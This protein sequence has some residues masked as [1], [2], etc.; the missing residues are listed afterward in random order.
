MVEADLKD[1]LIIGLNEID[2]W[3]IGNATL[4]VNSQGFGI[5]EKIKGQVSRKID[6]A[7]SLAILYET[8]R[9]YRTSFVENI[10]G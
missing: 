10:G 9:R 6:G 7:V 5:L 4:K 1:R 8:F 2:R 3:C